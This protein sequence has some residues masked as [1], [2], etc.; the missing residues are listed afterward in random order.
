MFPLVYG[1][2]SEIVRAKDIHIE[3]VQQRLAVAIKNGIFNKWMCIPRKA[4]QHRGAFLT[5]N[6]EMGVKTV[7][8]CNH[9]KIK[10]PTNVDGA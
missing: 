5:C 3:T 6:Y 1:K 2:L 4:P 7:R 9:R 8:Y 10:P